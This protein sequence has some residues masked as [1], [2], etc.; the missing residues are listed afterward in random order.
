MESS[1]ENAVTPEDYIG[2]VEVSLKPLHGSSPDFQ[3]HDF[4]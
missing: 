1:D 3:L 2:T 4:S